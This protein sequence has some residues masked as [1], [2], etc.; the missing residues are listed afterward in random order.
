MANTI[1]KCPSCK[2]LG[3]INNHTCPLCKGFGVP[4]YDEEFDNA[5]QFLGE[6]DELDDDED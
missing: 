4:L 2:G 5:K 6:S 1:K 3:L